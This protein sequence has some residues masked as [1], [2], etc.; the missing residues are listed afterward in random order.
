[1]WSQINSRDS[2][3]QSQ[4]VQRQQYLCL[5]VNIQSTSLE[6]ALKA[7]PSR[8]NTDSFSAVLIFPLE[9]AYLANLLH[10]GFQGAR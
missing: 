4:W 9:Y 8:L 7:Y 5:L 2:I 6:V 1:M 3:C 10:P